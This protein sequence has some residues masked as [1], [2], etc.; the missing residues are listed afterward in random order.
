MANVNGPFG[1]RP[2]SMKSGAPYNGATRTYYVP[3]SN[4]TALFI[5]DPVTMV[6]NSSD[7]NGV[8][9]VQIATAGDSGQI[10]GCMQ[11]I[12]NNAGQRIITLQQTQTPYLPAGQAAYIHVSDDPDLLYL[13]QEDGAAAGFMVSGAS[14]RNATMLAGA[15][16]TGNSLSGWTMQTSSLAVT[17]A[18]QL[19]IIQ[20]LQQAD[21]AVGQYARWLVKIN[22][23]I[24]PFDIALGV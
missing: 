15:G 1:L 21:N 23:G 12:T 14:G 7:G 13:V 5:G 17:A 8:Q 16:N 3:A 2:Y 6:T 19:R 20:L 11:G 9:T 22:Q 4:P 24:H 18:H 10:L